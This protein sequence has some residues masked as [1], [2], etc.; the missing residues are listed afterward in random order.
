[1]I[2]L[3]LTSK[4]NLVIIY[5]NLLM[6]VFVLAAISK[7]FIFIPMDD[8]HDI[9]G[10]PWESRHPVI[11]RNGICCLIEPHESSMF[12]IRPLVF[13]L[14]VA[15]AESIQINLLC[16][17]LRQKHGWSRIKE[18]HLIF[19]LRL[20]SKLQ[21]SCIHCNCETFHYRKSNHWILVS[22]CCKSLG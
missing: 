10:K 19:N 1:M 20:S 2:H 18:P 6:G 3:F 14:V 8:L 4:I 7:Q 21:P 22:G 16:D 11:I 15:K 13:Q 12:R 5:F 9:H 17:I